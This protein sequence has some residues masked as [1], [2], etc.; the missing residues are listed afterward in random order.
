MWTRIGNIDTRYTYKSPHVK[1]ILPNISVYSK[2]CGICRITTYKVN[3]ELQKIYIYIYIITVII[4]IM[5][6]IIIII[7]MIIIKRER[8]T[9]VRTVR[10]FWY[11]PNSYL[12]V[13]QIRLALLGLALEAPSHR[14]WW[15]RKRVPSQ[16]K[17]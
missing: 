7:T 2:P 12:Q 16:R 8:D 1:Q 14:R 6:M 13:D 17:C 15:E 4:I 3:H 5:I 9:F 10:I 11:I